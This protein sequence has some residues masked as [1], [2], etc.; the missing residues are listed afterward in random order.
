MINIE[1]DGM[2]IIAQKDRN[3]QWII[4]LVCSLSLLIGLFVLFGL[5][6]NIDLLTRWSSE[7]IPMAPV[8]AI[9]S[10]FFCLAFLGNWYYPAVKSLK[11][12]ILIVIGLISVYSLLLLLE[13][14]FSFRLTLDDILF[15][16]TI[17]F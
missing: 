4:A 15:P 11:T 1:N 10:V 5:F 17:Y 16:V 3:L 14:M 13:Y 2:K 8:T 7:F 6:F 9:I 12:A